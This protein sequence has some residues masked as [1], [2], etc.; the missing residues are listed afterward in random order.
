MLGKVLLRRPEIAVRWR[1][2]ALAGENEVYI[3]VGSF[4]RP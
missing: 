1:D 3:E 4:P 2:D